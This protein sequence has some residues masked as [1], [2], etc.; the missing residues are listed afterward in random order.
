MIEKRL[1]PLI[2]ISVMLIPAGEMILWCSGTGMVH[3]VNRCGRPTA[4]RSVGD[5]GVKLNAIG[6]A[7]YTKGLVGEGVSRRQTLCSLWEIEPFMVPVVD[8]AG[9]SRPDTSGE[10]D[11]RFCRLNRIK[12]DFDFSSGV[13]RDGATKCPAKHLGSEANAEIGDIGR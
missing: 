6:R 8:M 1:E 11:P 2:D 3:F 12:S 7:A 10:F 9:P 5:F 13:R 4:Y